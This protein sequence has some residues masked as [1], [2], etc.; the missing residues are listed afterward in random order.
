MNTTSIQAFEPREQL[1]AYAATKATIA[2][3]TKSL[4]KPAGKQGVRVN[5]VAP[6]AV[7]TP[8]I[9]WTMPAEKVK[10]FGENTIFKRPAQPKI[11]LYSSPLPT[12]AM[13]RAKNIWRD[14][15]QDTI[16]SSPRLQDS[17]YG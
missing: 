2:N 1:V 15:W 13:N 16:V 3:M 10:T 4:A 8:L 9:P 6:G 14:R 5:P 17:S 11:Y 7:W 12:R